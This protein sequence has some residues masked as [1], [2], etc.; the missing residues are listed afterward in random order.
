[1]EVWE[2]WSSSHCMSAAGSSFWTAWACQSRDHGGP[3]AGQSIFI[4]NQTPVFSDNSFPP[5]PV[6][7]PVLRENPCCFTEKKHGP[8]CW[9]SLKESIQCPLFL[10][11]LAFYAD[12]SRLHGPSS[13]I[14]SKTGIWCDAQDSF[15]LWNCVHLIVL[16]QACGV[17]CVSD[18][19]RSLIRLHWK[20]QLRYFFIFSA[21]LNQT[22]RSPLPHVEIHLFMHRN[23]AL[24]INGSHRG[25]VLDL[26]RL[27]DPVFVLIL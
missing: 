3:A 11:V 24:L 9:L 26:Y 27:F 22:C 13:R 20:M 21:S 17:I 6:F 15:V 23:I 14:M 2:Q 5:V 19:L 10:F 4:T 1:M 16:I 25:G 7:F 18:V 12:R 8:K